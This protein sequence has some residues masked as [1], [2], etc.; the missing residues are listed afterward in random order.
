MSTTQGEQEE[1]GLFAT[2]ELSLARRFREA[3]RK[4]RRSTQRRTTETG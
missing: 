2:G 3:E 4:G 1:K